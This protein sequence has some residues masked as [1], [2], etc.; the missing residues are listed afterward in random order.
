MSRSH[1]T[2]TAEFFGRHYLKLVA[3][4]GSLLAKERHNLTVSNETVQEFINSNVERLPE[5]ARLAT[6]HNL[7]HVE[8]ASNLADYFAR[9]DRNSRA[10]GPVDCVE[11][12]PWKVCP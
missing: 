2:G 6:E 10:K 12:R 8:M 4:Q 11:D 5:I 7:G 1:E 9:E 3:A